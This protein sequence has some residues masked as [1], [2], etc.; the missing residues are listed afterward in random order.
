MSVD[1]SPGQAAEILGVSRSLVYRLVERGE[2][3][4]YRLSN[5]L[6][7]PRAGLE[8]LRERNWIRSQPAPAYEPVPRSRPRPVTD[9][10]SADV[11]TMQVGRSG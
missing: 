2:L 11:R 9:S 6:R 1:L 5:R 3:R 7:I 4:A 8:E 10:F